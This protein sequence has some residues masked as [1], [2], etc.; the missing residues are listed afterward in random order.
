[1]LIQTIDGIG[2][3]ANLVGANPCVRADEHTGLSRRTHGFVAT[4]E[5]ILLLLAIATFA[6]NT[7][8]T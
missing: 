2:V 6:T 3:G 8:V 1:M 4:N 5:K 7:A